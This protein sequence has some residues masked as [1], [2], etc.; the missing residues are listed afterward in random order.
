MF[1]PRRGGHAG[2]MKT[3]LFVIVLL[4]FCALC[5]RPERDVAVRSLT[6]AV[7]R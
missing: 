5:V 2:P 1:G 3:R 4:L 6:V 7:V